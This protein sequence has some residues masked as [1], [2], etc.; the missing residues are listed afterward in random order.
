MKKVIIF[1]LG[2]VIAG[3]LVYVNS[4][5]FAKIDDH[6]KYVKG[7]ISHTAAHI[8]YGIKLLNNGDD[9]IFFKGSNTS[10]NDN[11]CYKAFSTFN[12]ISLNLNEGVFKTITYE[13]I[14]NIIEHPC[15]VYTDPETI[16][17]ISKQAKKDIPDNELVKGK[18]ACL[19]FL[20]KEY[21]VLMSMFDQKGKIKTQH[22]FIFNNKE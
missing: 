5:T 1:V 17:I 16:K 8:Q 7:S 9:S 21:R 3:I 10:A 11:S 15:S 18:N 2:F 13:K 6:K 19:S 20:A 14:K 22:Y 12:C 4:G